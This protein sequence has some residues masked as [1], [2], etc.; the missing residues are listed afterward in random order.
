M[1]A[2]VDSEASVDF[3]P[4]SN[5]PHFS[6]VEDNGQK[7]NVWFL[8]AVTAYNE[9]HAADVYQPAGYAIWRLG[10]E[11]PS[12]WSVMGR[13]Y[14]AT[15]PATLDTIPAGYDIDLEGNGEI[16]KVAARPSDGSRKLEVDADTKDIDEED[17]MSLPTTYVVKTIGGPPQKL[18]LTFD[19]G[20]DPV[21]D[22]EDPGR[23][24]EKMRRPHSSS[25]ATTP[26]TIRTWCAARSKMERGR[27]PHL[28]PPECRRH[29]A[30]DRAPRDQCHATALRVGHRA[31]DA[32]VP[33]AL[34]R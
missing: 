22:T 34:S 15:A 18:A 24:A 1:Q 10:S 5:N 16:L 8:D 29:S 2:A 20:P 30:G 6:Y 13:P 7:H 31:L 23:A 17:Y 12:L 28:H 9:I 11:D 3:D 19:D 25:W 32:P 33:A 26:P 21:V 14:G 4:D 27:Q